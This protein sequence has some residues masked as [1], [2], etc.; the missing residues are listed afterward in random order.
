MLTTATISNVMFHA[1][2]TDVTI[3]PEKS[4]INI[5]TLMDLVFVYFKVHTYLFQLFHRMLCTGK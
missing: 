1:V 2:E 4:H 3:N 5:T